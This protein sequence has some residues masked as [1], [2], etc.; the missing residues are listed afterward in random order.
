MK[1]FLLVLCVITV[2]MLC[3]LFVSC[4][5]DSDK[6]AGEETTKEE[7]IEATEPAE[8]MTDDIYVEITAQQMYLNSIFAEKQEEGM[9]QEKALKYATE[10]N[11][12]MSELYKEHGVTEKAFS[13]YS[14]K[15]MEDYESYGAIME[16]VNKRVEELKKEK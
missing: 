9:S 13:E 5:G 8:E 6:E 14:D 3:F 7:V 1:N 12:K 10:L 16:R 2:T 11:E 15:L 4:A